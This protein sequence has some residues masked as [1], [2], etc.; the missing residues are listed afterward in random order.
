MAIPCLPL[1]APGGE[2]EE[3][4]EE[5]VVVVV[6]VE[7]EAVGEHGRAMGEACALAITERMPRGAAGMP[8]APKPAA[9]ASVSRTTKN[10]W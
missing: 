5:V 9:A 8:P 10:A 2:E 1:P 6:V 4:E 7:E 3:E